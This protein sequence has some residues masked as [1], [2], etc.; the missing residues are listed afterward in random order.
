MQELCREVEE[1]LVDAIDLGMPA[2][3]PDPAQAKL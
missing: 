1:S 3:E 2:A